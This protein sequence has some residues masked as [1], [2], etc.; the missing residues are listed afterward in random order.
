MSE[1][2][3]LERHIQSIQQTRQITNAMYLTSSSKMRKALKLYEDNKAYMTGIYPVLK[4][5][6]QHPA[7][8][9]LPVFH[10]QQERKYGYIVITS[11]QGLAG[12]YNAEVLALAEEAMRDRKPSL[13]YVVGN[14]GDQ[15]FRQKR[16]N[17]NP[18]FKERFRQI[19][20]RGARYA[21]QTLF[22]EIE[23]RSITD[24]YLVYTRMESVF[25]HKPVVRRLLPLIAEDYEDQ[26]PLLIPEEAE[27]LPSPESV[28]SHTLNIYLMGR[29][30][31]AV[32]QS[33][34][35]EHSVRM[36]AMESATRNADEM[37]FLLRK[38]ANQARQEKITQEITEIASGSM[39][40]GGDV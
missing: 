17:V 28:L 21:A 39:A 6:M 9:D 35:A 36:R 14:V 2:A 37:L 20:K 25:Q 38:K 40:I 12:S 23:D 5:L 22:D 13:L 8:K 26:R 31:H 7:C 16:Y 1:L 29:I 30:Y 27:L 10:R 32:V 24:F 34:A 18:E 3:E 33:Y 11:D 19:S 15:Y 4:L